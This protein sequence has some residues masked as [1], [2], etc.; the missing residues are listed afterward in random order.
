MLERLRAAWPDALQQD[1]RYAMRRSPG[2]G[3]CGDRHRD[4]DGGIGACTAMFSIVQAVLLR[5]L[6]VDA[7]DR[8]TMLGRRH[9]PAGPRRA[10]LLGPPRLRR[11]PGVRGRRARRIGELVGDPASSRGQPVGLPNS[12]VSATFFD[13]LGARPFSGEPSAR[14]TIEPSAPPVLVLS[15]GSW[16]QYFGADP[17]V[18]GRKVHGAR[19]GAG[20]R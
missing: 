9:A 6:A 19:G 18:V 2:A 1:V 3:I 11:H 17:G 12:A 20:S 5:P 4:P 15:H 16:R 14:K 10:D 7:P 13:V 8:V